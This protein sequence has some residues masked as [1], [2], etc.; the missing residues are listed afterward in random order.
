METATAAVRLRSDVW[1]RYS[2]EAQALGVSMG[3]YLRRRLEEQDR[4][5]AEFAALRAAV[6]RSEPARALVA[7]DLPAILVG[8]IVEVLLL[9]RSLVG[10]QKA[11]V[12]QKEVE[13]RGLEMWR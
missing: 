9:L 13:R 7:P 11:A 4:L 8:A 2:A 1:T 6:E 10:P 12:A 5:A 3:T